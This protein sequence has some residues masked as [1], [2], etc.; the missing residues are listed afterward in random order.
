MKSSKFTCGNNS[1]DRECIL[2]RY[3]MADGTQSSET[4]RFSSDEKFQ[5]GVY[6]SGY[7]SAR[8]KE[9]RSDIH[10]LV[11]GDSGALCRAGDWGGSAT[12]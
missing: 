1:H 5:G 8:R 4:I 6:R 9:S 11:I 2:L 12:M 10:C 7:L 3:I